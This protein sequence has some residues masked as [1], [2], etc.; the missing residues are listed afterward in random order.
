MKY[1]TIVADPPWPEPMTGHYKQTRHSRP[2]ALPYATMTVED[3]AALPVADWAADGAHLWLWTTNRHMEAGFRVLQAWGFTYLTTITWVKP[4]GLGNYFVSRTQHCL[5]GY[6]DRCVFPQ[7]RY[8]PNVLFAPAH[9]HSA[10]P[11]AFYDFVE[12]ISPAP[13]L[14]MFARRQRFN[15]DTWGNECYV[16]DGLKLEVP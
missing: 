1:R 9:Q 5:F 12:E 2:A 16:P 3:I 6:K 7:A 8:R 14:E 13:R 4:S 15:F 10:K 11:D